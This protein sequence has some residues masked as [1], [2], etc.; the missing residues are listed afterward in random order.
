MNLSL[1]F[2]IHQLD[3][4]LSEPSK[5]MCIYGKVSKVRTRF[6]ILGSRLCVSISVS[7]SVLMPSAV[8]D[9][10]LFLLFSH[11]LIVYAAA[12]RKEINY[13]H[14]TESEWERWAYYAADLLY[15]DLSHNDV[16]YLQ[17]LKQKRRIALYVLMALPNW[18]FFSHT[19]N[20]YRKL[21]L[22]FRIRPAD[23]L[24]LTNPGA[25]CP[26]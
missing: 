7:V 16:N 8:S 17:A 26:T 22:I 21:T 24:N 13:V 10:F 12:N 18:K 9:R 14:G 6:E 23:V 4:R 1:V 3:C 25:D 5:Y 15:K 2:L 19:T 20:S 11:Y